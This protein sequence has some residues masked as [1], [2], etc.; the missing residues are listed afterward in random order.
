[1]IAAVI[2][3][4]PQSMRQLQLTL[5]TLFFIIFCMTLFFAIFIRDPD[6]F[7]HVKAGQD[8]LLNKAIP[9]TDPYSFT[10]AGG[11]WHAHE[12]LFEIIIYLIFHTLGYFGVKAFVA[13]IGL[14]ALFISAAALS[15]RHN[16]DLPVIA[17]M[18]MLLAPFLTPRPQLFTFLFFAIYLFALLRYKYRRESYHLWGLAPLMVLWVNVHGGYLLGIAIIATFI[19]TEWLGAL[20]AQ[21]PTEQRLRLRPL[22]ITLLSVITA[23]LINP[24]GIHHWLFPFQLMNTSAVAA[25]SE[26]QP[27]DFS[28]FYARGY[29]AAI[30]LLLMVYLYTPRRPDITEVAIPWGMITASFIAVRHMPLAYLTI[31]PF[32][33]HKL[34]EWVTSTSFTN[35]LWV[36]R[37]RNRL[38]QGNDLGSKEV[39]LNWIILLV[40]TLL[41]TASYPLHHANDEAKLNELVPAKATDFIVASHLTGRMFNTYHYGGYLIFRLAP[42]QQVF[43]DIRGDMYGGGVM[44]DY[45]AA[46]Q[47]RPGWQTILDRYAIDYIVCESKA[48]LLE[49]ATASGLFAPVYRDRE[50]TVLVRTGGRYQP[51]I[52]AYRPTPY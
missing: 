23:S 48:P 43:I 44:D 34:T 18:A 49:A 8:I 47:A 3:S 39:I 1:M 52:S 25:I 42:L 51:L 11:I 36:T 2:R 40:V 46:Y 30:A 27:I 41:F 20:L 28:S 32:L 24:W 13:L 5:R 21:T 19:V 35:H 7:F 22:I 33:I 45:I 14:A 9:A 6:F 16:A 29:L 38:S 31:T 12:W 15:K 50:S 17:V 26:W 4:L 10:H 37:L